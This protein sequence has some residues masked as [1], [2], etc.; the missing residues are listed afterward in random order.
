[1]V[2]ELEARVTIWPPKMSSSSR[3][4]LRLRSM[5]VTWAPMP[6][7]ILAALVP[8]TP[9]PMMTTVGGRDAGDA[10]EEHAASAVGGFEILRAHLDGHAAGDFAHGGEQW[11]GSIGIV[12]GFVGYAVD[13]GLEHAVGE[14]GQGGQVEVGKENEAGAEEIVLLGLGLFHFDDEVGAAPNFGGGGQD[15]AA[16]FQVLFVG[17]GAAYAGG[18]LDQNLVSGFAQGFGGA[19]NETDAGLMIFNFFG[20]ADDHRECSSMEWC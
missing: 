12:N 9:P 16:C 10:A 4:R 2:Q 15:G 8:T 18:G 5:M 11:E 6:R 1:M 13:L 19:G 3:R 14:F 17:K 7:A 20:N